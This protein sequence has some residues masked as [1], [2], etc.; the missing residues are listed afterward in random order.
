MTP[1]EAG[2][3]NGRTYTYNIVDG[4][5]FEI[6]RGVYTSSGNTLSRNVIVS[7]IGGTLGTSRLNLS[8]TAQ[9]RFV[10]LA[11]DMDGVRG[12]RAVTGTTDVLM[13]SDLG[14]VVT[15]TNASAVAVS[16]AQAGSSNLFLD[17]WATF[18][19]NKGAGAVTI[20]PVA[21]TIDGAATLVLSQNQGA[22]IWS[23]GTNY[24]I[25][26]LGNIW[27]GPAGLSPA[28]QSQARS[29]VYAA[30]FDALAYNGMQVNGHHDISQENGSN[31]VSF[32]TGTQNKYVTDNWR[33]YKS[34]TSVLSLQRVASGID[35][36][37][38]A[39]QATVST[40]Q[41]SIGA[42]V[43]LFGTWIEGSRF[44]RCAWGTSNAVPV[45]VGFWFKAAKT[46]TYALIAYNFDA[47]SNQT[48]SFSV[49]SANTWTWCTATFAAKTTGTWKTDANSGFEFQVQI[50]GG[51][52]PNN[53]D[54]V[55]NVVAITALVVLPGI[56]LPSSA[57]LP[58]ILRP[59]DQ[60]A[61]Q[62]DR[63]WQTFGNVGSASGANFGAGVMAASTVGIIS[64]QFRGSGMRVVPALSYS[65]ASDFSILDGAFSTAPSS[66][67]LDNWATNQSCNI[68]VAISGA[69]QGKGAWLRSANTNARMHFSA[70]F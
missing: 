63:L 37:P 23:D 68:N 34:G 50:A 44:A 6:G 52:S 33:F 11:E 70:R 54:A 43:A 36:I 65:S 27:D 14:Y 4:N 51:G 9:V 7:R 47:S 61:V 26:R 49:T 62:C 19:K 39:M 53:L 24:Q 20:T 22:M 17:G 31:A 66:M 21:C 67:T 40:A 45:S 12:T 28:Q 30:P 8:G 2:A 15:Y 13:N 38:F 55:S 42:D 41:A 69:T 46:G 58:R 25:F 59:S 16:L 60:E 5:D 29:N 1:A 35:G 57:Q 32:S 48:T 56:E 3:I 64:L 10:E 18:V